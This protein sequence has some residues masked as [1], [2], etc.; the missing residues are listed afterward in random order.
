MNAKDLSK[1]LQDYGLTPV[2]DLKYY[3]NV[4]SR[5]VNSNYSDH[6]LDSFR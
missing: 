4:N 5:I 6:D 3:K 2:S 1:L